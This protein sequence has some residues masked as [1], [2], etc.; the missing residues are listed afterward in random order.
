MSTRHGTPLFARLLLVALAMGCGG[1]S[2]DTAVSGRPDASPP[3]DAG[4]DATTGED[5]EA[6]WHYPDGFLWGT[7][8]AGFQV[9]MGCPTLS[10]SV[11][12]D[13]RS[14]WYA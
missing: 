13:A 6:F 3:A 10:D 7:A 5:P 8:M 11:C 1:R 12:A 2:I 4:T 9:D 14:D